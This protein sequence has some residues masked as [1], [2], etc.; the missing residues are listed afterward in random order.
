M[1]EFNRRHRYLIEPSLQI[2]MFLFSFFLI[3]I[4]VAI[5]LLV[6]YGVL[7]SVVAELSR[8]GCMD[9]ANF[10]GLF[11]RRSVPVLAFALFVVVVFSFVAVIF[12]SHKI[13]GPLYRLKKYMEI[14]SD[15][16]FNVRVSFRRGDKIRDVAEA[17]NSMVEKL[18]ERQRRALS[19]VEELEKGKRSESERVLFSHL[20]K[21]I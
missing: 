20:K 19:I 18:Q 12:Y 8:Q 15:G 13:A 14:V 3:L 16:D 7:N 1:N 4:A 5:V 21:Y 9:A 2:S 10:S 6:F 11:W 17:F